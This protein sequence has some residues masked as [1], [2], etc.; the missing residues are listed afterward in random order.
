MFQGLLSPE[1]PEKCS[2]VPVNLKT[3]FRRRKILTEFGSEEKWNYSWRVKQR[4]YVYKWLC[5][6]FYIS[7]IHRNLKHIQ[8]HKCLEWKLWSQQIWL[9][10]RW[11]YFYTDLFW[12]TSRVHW[13]KWARSSLL[14]S[15]LSYVIVNRF[16]Q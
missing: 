16:M 1:P 6:N 7:K 5:L 11:Y 4:S 9:R 14:Y 3:Q 12:T 13:C 15:C 2:E 10:R 8:D